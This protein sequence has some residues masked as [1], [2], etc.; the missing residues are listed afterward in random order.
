MMNST[1]G[2]RIFCLILPVTASQFNTPVTE[3]ARDRVMSGFRM[4]EQAPHAL[5]TFLLNHMSWF[6][7]AQRFRMLGIAGACL[8]CARLLHQYDGMLLHQRYSSQSTVSLLVK[9][10]MDS[11]SHA[12][13]ALELG[14]SC[15]K[16]VHT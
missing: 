10:H 9:Q 5:G 6:I 14:R 2:F 4:I 7:G 13:G 1:P 16:S 11:V 3:H 12:G 8:Q 15:H